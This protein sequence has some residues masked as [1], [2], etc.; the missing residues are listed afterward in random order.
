MKKTNNFTDAENRENK[1]TDNI[2]SVQSSLV[3]LISCIEVENNTPS[4]LGSIVLLSL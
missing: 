1:K 3:C 2:N 4:P